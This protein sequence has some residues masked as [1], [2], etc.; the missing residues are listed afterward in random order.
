MMM[1]HIQENP[2]LAVVVAL[3]LGGGGAGWAGMQMGDR[4][5]ATAAAKAWEAQARINQVVT[6]NLAKLDERQRESEKTLA[7]LGGPGDPMSPRVRAL[8][9]ASQETANTLVRVSVMLAAI[10]KRQMMLEDQR[11]E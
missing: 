8:E 4:W 7:G 1:R 10:E 2:L 5:T 11:R 3:I 9:K 6:D